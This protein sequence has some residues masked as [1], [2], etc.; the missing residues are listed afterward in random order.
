MPEDDDLVLNV[1]DQT[2]SLADIAGINMDDIEEVR[3]FVFPRMIA[4]WKIVE[5]KLTVMKQKDTKVAVA[6]WQFECMEPLAFANAE[7]ESRAESFVGKKHMEG[8]KFI[9]TDPKETLGRI[10]AFMSDTGFKGAGVL[11][12]LL[13]QFVDLE[14]IGR[15]SVNADA[16][17]PDKKYNNFQLQFGDWK[18]AAIK[19]D[20]TPAKD[21]KL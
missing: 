17:D 15:I 13:Q 16:N 10:K 1:G 8:I 4:R 5:S 7:D 3:R 11:Q 20:G 2:A 19:E 14:F 12:E 21:M 18:V 6:N 9:D